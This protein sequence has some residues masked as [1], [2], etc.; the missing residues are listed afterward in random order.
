MK[1][2]LP[3]LKNLLEANVLEIKFTR[4]KP[5]PGSAATRRMFCTLSYTLLNSPNGR[6]ALGFSG[7][8]NNMKFNPTSKNLVPVWDLFKRQYR[9]VNADNCE[10]ISTIP[11][12][13][14]FWLYY[15]D[16]ISKM[17]PPEILSFY[18]S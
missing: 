5:K 18:D 17:T 13:E 3:T 6:K 10:L 15:N 1:I 4:R 7:S 11:A 9:L 2:A 14:D 12:N 8:S 16:H